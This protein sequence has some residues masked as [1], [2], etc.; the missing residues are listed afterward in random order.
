MPEVDFAAE[1]PPLFG[2]AQRINSLQG[3]TNF[4][5]VVSSSLEHSS[6]CNIFPRHHKTN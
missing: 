2:N 3:K 4:L 5:H 1:P 6:Y